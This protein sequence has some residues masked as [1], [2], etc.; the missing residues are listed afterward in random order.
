MPE[1]FE[2]ISLILNGPVEIVQNAVVPGC[3]LLDPPQNSSLVPMY[4]ELAVLVMPYKYSTHANETP[5]L[6]EGR[7]GLGCMCQPS[8]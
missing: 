3:I 1:T 7:W 2:S 6:V 8:N 5:F 4:C